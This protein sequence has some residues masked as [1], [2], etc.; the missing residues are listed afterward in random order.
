MWL[1]LM[2]RRPHNKGSDAI[3]PDCGQSAE[4]I[5][6]IH[7]N[8]KERPSSFSLSKKPNMEQWIE[9]YKGQKARETRNRQARFPTKGRKGHVLTPFLKGKVYFNDEKKRTR[10]SLNGE[11]RKKEWVGVLPRSCGPQVHHGKKKITKGK[12]G[13]YSVCLSAPSHG[14]RGGLGKEDKE[15]P[16]EDFLLELKQIREEWK[17]TGGG[18]EQTLFFSM[19]SVHIDEKE[20]TK[21]KAKHARV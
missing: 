12:H 13:S 11:E 5:P 20:K 18:R 6:A 2:P 17:H 4:A 21:E 7:P 8:R 15:E 14:S 10:E 16:R 3:F 9:K 19:D 1:N